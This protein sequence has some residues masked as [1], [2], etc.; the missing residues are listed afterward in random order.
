MGLLR[1]YNQEQ[2]IHLGCQQ[3]E[4]S[5]EESK[6]ARSFSYS[7]TLQVFSKLCQKGLNCEI[8]QIVL[9]IQREGLLP[10]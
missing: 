4:V 7:H 9:Q 5:S 8:Q 6:A 1:E 10:S 3:V 2:L